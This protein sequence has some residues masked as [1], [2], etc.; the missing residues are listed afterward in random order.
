MVVVLKNI[1]FLKWK[2]KVCKLKIMYFIIG[3]KIFNK[4]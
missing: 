3:N 2:L 4:K 1:L